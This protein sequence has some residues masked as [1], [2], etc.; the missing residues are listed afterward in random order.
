MFYE[1]IDASRY[2]FE[3]EIPSVLIILNQKEKKSNQKLHV[4]QIE[5]ALNSWKFDLVE[6]NNWNVSQIFQSDFSKREKTPSR[7]ISIFPLKNILIRNRKEYWREP[8][9]VKHLFP[10]H[11]SH[12][13]YSHP[14][15]F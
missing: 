13:I 1:T 5:Q 10:F 7:H 9:N 14:C 11:V 2:F 6:R 8:N 4:T 3:F 12:S 15:D